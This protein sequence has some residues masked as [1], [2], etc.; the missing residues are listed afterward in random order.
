MAQSFQELLVTNYGLQ[1]SGYTGSQGITGYTGSSGVAGT[2][3]GPKITAI[4]VTNSSYTVLDDTA[5]DVAGGYIKIVGTGFESGCQV[6]VNNTPAT[7]TTFIGSTEVRAQ[8]PATAA[9]TYI[10]YLVNADGGV[11]IRINGV[12]F[13]TTPVWSTA[14][15][16]PAGDDGAAISISLSAVGASTYSLQAGS[17]LPGTLT[18]SSAGLLSGSVADLAGETTFSFTVVA[19]DAELQDSPRTFSITITAGDPQIAYVSTL[20]S[21]QLSTLPFNDDA[22]ANN[23]AVTVFGDSR[24]N[25][26]G[27]YTPGYYSNF[28]DGTG[29]YLSFTLTNNIGTGDFTMEAWVYPTSTLSGW[30]DILVLWPGARGILLGGGVFT[31]YNLAGTGVNLSSTY[32]V[33][34]NNWQHLA[35]TRSN[36]TLYMFANGVQVGTQS[37]S[38]SITNTGTSYIGTWAGASEFFPGF[39]SNLRLVIGTAL[40]TAAFT[41]PTQPLTAVAGTNLLTC[42]SNR[43]IDNSTN[44]FALTRFGDA[45]IDGF[46]PF[47]PATEFAGRGSTYF[48]GTG[49]YLDVP[50]N[51]AF[52]YGT[53]DFTIEFWAYFTSI[54]GS[55]PNLID[56]RSAT[57]TQVVPTIYLNA[58]T[59]TLY[60]NGGNRLAG[61]AVVANRWYHIALCRAS[62]QTR[63]FIDGT[64]SGSTYADSN[65]YINSPVRVFGSNDGSAVQAQAGYCSNL[66]IVKGTALYTT[67]FTPPTSPLTAISGTSLLICQTNQPANN[68]T[69]LDSSTNNFLV[70]RNGNATQ[71]TLSPYGGGWSNYFDGTGD[72]LTAPTTLPGLGSIDFT[73]ESWVYP[74]S[75][76]S[77]TAFFINGD[78]STYAAVRVGTQ[79]NQIY[80]LMA[81]TTGA[82]AVSSGLVGSAPINTW[83]HVAVSRSGTSVKLFLN[84]TQVG[85]SYTVSGSLLAGA[86]NTIGAY[87]V[88]PFEYFNGYIS[89]ARIVRGSALYTTNFTP[90]T[91]PLQPIAGTSLLTCADNR[92]IDDSPNN[93]A[94]TRTGDVSVQKFN[95]FGIQT[96]MTPVTHS[97]F[98]DGTGDLLTP[99]GTGSLVRSTGSFTIEGWYYPTSSAASFRAVYSSGTG[100]ATAGRLYQNNTA[101]TFYW[102]ASSSIAGSIGWTLNTWNHFAVTWDGTTTKVYVNGQQ[103]ISSTSPTYSGTTDLSIGESTYSP[104]GYI[105]NFRIVSSVVYAANFTPST[106]PLAA[107][108]GTILLTCQSSTFVDNSTNR[109]AITAAGNSQPS[110]TN[111]FGYIAGTKQNYTPSVYGGSMYFDGT[112][113]YLSVPDSV[114][115]DFTGDFTMEAWVYANA[116]S[117]DNAIAAQWV[118]GQLNF[119]FKIVTTGGRPYFTAFAGSSVIVQGTTTAVTINTWNHVAVTRSGSTIRLF[120]NG[121]LDATTGTVTG[122]ISAAT[123]LTIGSVSTTQY[124]NGYISNFRIVKGT[125]LYTSNFVPPVAPL[126]A[127]SNTVLLVDGTSAAICDASANNNLET[128]GDAKLSTTVVKYGNT[129]MS[130]DGTGDYLI[131]P[132]SPSTMLGTGD[133]TIEFWLN[134]SGGARYVEFGNGLLYRDGNGKLVYYAS[135]ATRITSTAVLLL[136]STWVHIALVRQ[137]GSSKLYIDGIQTGSTFADTINY[138]L[139]TLVIGTDGGSKTEFFAGHISDLRITRGVARYTATFTPPASA[140][141]AK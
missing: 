67:A 119:L 4:Q 33:T 59:L 29:D 74:T 137:S 101:L 17:T 97:V 116:L 92:L 28:F 123:P 138:T 70:T 39:I 100:Y 96:A 108:S 43:F 88:T 66:R 11:A 3:G 129:S 80:L 114:A 54:S 113:D 15:S 141:K 49:D 71:G 47:L 34:L 68:N 48:D 134:T 112:G 7:A 21:P 107:I 94:I 118:T 36:G 140:S 46:D 18:L 98:F 131:A 5:V 56:Q 19:T 111:P 85:T 60:I 12:T 40:Y 69:F 125:A 6:L 79:S 93:F 32:T 89:N 75:T 130:F 86:I 136:N 82:W 42:Q 128:V 83:N 35:I 38:V 77:G 53:G 84:G 121:V 72:N 104:F 124:W 14:S 95:P 115:F 23:F 50:S 73:V 20:L 117:T 37:S 9:G 25:N 10:V 127:V 78:T 63:F 105:S 65:N 2:G 103:T 16:L 62:G 26:F 64:Q 58:G 135:N 90:P 81:T 110:P 13:S 27:P 76:A 122:T 31:A 41:P 139:G 99:A 55:T 52:G 132:N 133:F 51:A 8:V 87:T 24:P 1:P 30:N 22:S 44:N 106:A 126:A 109:F 91:A 120:V 61:T 45:R 57:S 102:G